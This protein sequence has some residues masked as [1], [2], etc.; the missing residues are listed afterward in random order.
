MAFFLEFLNSLVGPKTTYFLGPMA[1]WRFVCMFPT[2]G[3]MDS[4][5]LPDTISS[6]MTAG[7]IFMAIAFLFLFK[8]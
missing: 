7:E 6:N 3:M 5:N 2:S 1:N 8:P 4:K